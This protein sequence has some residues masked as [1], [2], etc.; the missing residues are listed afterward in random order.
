VEEEGSCTAPSSSSDE[1]T[2]A[3]LEVGLFC[4]ESTSDSELAKGKLKDN[5]ASVMFGLTLL[6]IPLS[7]AAA[8]LSPQILSV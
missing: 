3:S 4:H 7:R 5:R 1:A 2:E 8:R 6:T